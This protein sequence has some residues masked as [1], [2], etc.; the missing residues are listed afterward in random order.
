LT[1]GW[2]TVRSAMDP[3]FGIRA[4]EVEA[5]PLAVVI[6]L[7]IG[8]S[9]FQQLQPRNASDYAKEARP[10]FCKVPLR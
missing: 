10:K 9:T 4:L 2:A 3:G 1:S 7:P 8:C 6:L 5:L